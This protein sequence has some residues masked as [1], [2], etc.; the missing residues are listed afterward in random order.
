MIRNTAMKLKD[1][2]VVL[3]EEL[4]TSGHLLYD[5]RREILDA[6]RMLLNLSKAELGVQDCLKALNLAQTATLLFKDKNFADALRLVDELQSTQMR[7]VEGF[8][9]AERLKAWIPQQLAATKTFAMNQVKAWLADTREASEA[10]GRE[11]LQKSQDRLEKW[12]RSPHGSALS[13]LSSA[14]EAEFE[15]AAAL[16]RLVTFDGLLE[17]L[18]LFEL[19]GHSKEFAGLLCESRRQQLDIVLQ[20]QVHFT[21]DSELRGLQR[22]FELLAG[23]FVVE[24]H[25]AQLPQE[26]YAW[27]WVEALWEAALKRIDEVVQQGCAAGEEGAR[28]RLMRIKWVLVFTHSALRVYP[29]PLGR[30]VEILTS[31]FYKFVETMKLES[32]TTLTEHITEDDLTPISVSSADS[33]ARFRASFAFLRDPK[34]DDAVLLPFTQA[35]VETFA[36]VEAFVNYFYV[37]LDGVPQHSS[38]LDEIARKAIDNCLLREANRLLLERSINASLPQ[39]LGLYTDFGTLR[40]LCSDIEGLLTRERSACRTSPI[41][42]EARKMFESSQREIVAT[43]KDAMGK[44]VQRLTAGA[45]KLERIPAEKPGTPSPYLLDTIKFLTDTKTQLCETIDPDALEL[46]FR[47]AS[48][49]IADSLL[50]ILYDPAVP[51]MSLYYVHGLSDDLAFLEEAIAKLLPALQDALL[52]PFDELRETLALILAKSCHDYMDP[53]IRHDQYPHLQTEKIVRVLGKI[54]QPQAKRMSIEDLILL[55][56]KRQI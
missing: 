49:C 54:S 52:A 14:G 22:M 18:H 47:E 42:L 25:L 7:L 48:Q 28:A 46:L 38:E 4:S 55:L 10:I 2:S 24:Y 29:Y 50:A 32:V 33:V 12:S 35:V 39:L 5:C 16:V 9:F 13:S 37:F 17:S 20:A 1:R 19:M 31:L 36:A 15:D 40:L 51:G 53:G 43:I 26:V 23:F 6:Q 41:R 8:G 21:S 27:P 45:Q 30:L 44:E 11:A 34:Y 3:K 56:G